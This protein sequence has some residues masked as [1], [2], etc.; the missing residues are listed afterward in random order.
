MPDLGRSTKKPAHQ[1]NGSM[2]A[3]GAKPKGQ[4]VTPCALPCPAVGR[5]ARSD[6]PSLRGLPTRG[7]HPLVR[8]SQD[9]RNYMRT[10][11]R[12]FSIGLVPLIFVLGLAPLA[13]QLA[14]G[15]V[16]YHRLRSFGFEDL[17]ATDPSG[18]LIEGTNGMLYGVTDGGGEAGHGTVFRINKDGTGF[19][20][21]ISFTA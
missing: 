13:V 16:V 4:G 3:G 19:A 8:L 11:N 7:G 9:T 6:A 21:L 20:Q 10:R 15:Q 18:G 2:K 12:I 17:S 5:R 1:G 14:W